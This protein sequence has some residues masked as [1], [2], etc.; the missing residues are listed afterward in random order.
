MKKSTDHSGDVKNAYQKLKEAHQEIKNS[1]IETIYR[2]AIAAEYRD[3]ATGAHLMRISD[4][5]TLLGRKLGLPDSDVELLRFGSPMHDIGKIGIPDAILLKP[6]KLTEEEYNVM[7]QHTVIGARIF[8]G[9]NS[10][11]LKA[12]AAIALSHHEHY[13]GTG[14][15]NGLKGDK[16]PLF[17]RI[18][19]ISD[20]FDALMSE[21]SYKKAFRLERALDILKKEAGKLLDPHLVHIFLKSIKEVESI[22]SAY[23]T[24]ASFSEKGDEAS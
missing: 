11:L 7:K 1:Y 15:P 13:D 10:P 2:L 8:H 5:S 21:R 24:I 14:Y 12:S 17:G 20:V 22:L 18:V 3:M 19:C 4:Y 23:K 9:S 6:G 16:I